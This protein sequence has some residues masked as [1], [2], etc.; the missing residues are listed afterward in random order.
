MNKEKVLIILA[1][2]IIFAFSAVPA[3]LVTNLTSI[4]G[5]SKPWYSGYVNVTFSSNIHYWFF[6]S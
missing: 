2:Q 3:D 5:Y 4:T 6:P 1:L